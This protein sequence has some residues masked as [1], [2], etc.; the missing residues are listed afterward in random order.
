MSHDEAARLATVQSLVERHTLAIRPSA[1]FDTDR[2][3][4]INNRFYSDQPPALAVMLAG[5]YWI[6]K[7]IGGLTFDN[8]PVLVPYLLT[9]AGSTLPAAGAAGLVYRM[10]RM[11]ELRRT[12]RTALAAVVVFGSGMIAYATTIN[13]YAPA[14]TLVLGA[15][16][17][18][19]HVSRSLRP[20]RQ[21]GWLALGGLCAALAAV[22]EP[23]TLVILLGLPL[24]IWGMRWR[25]S[26]RL[27]GVMLYMIGALAPLVLHAKMVVPVTGDIRPAAWHPELTANPDDDDSPPDWWDTVTHELNHIMRRSLGVHGLL[28]HYPVLI[29][30]IIGIG[31]VMV[32]HWPAT[33]KA[34]AVVTLASATIPLLFGPSTEGEAMYGPWWFMAIA[35]LLAFWIAAFLRRGHT[36]AVWGLAAALLAFSVIVSLFGTIDCAR[37]G[38]LDGYS[39]VEVLRS[40]GPERRLGM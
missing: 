14:A 20:H 24:V 34:L 9:L 37:R 29:F 6:L 11:L 8:S 23:T 25:R 30:G 40:P 21:G 15:A 10:G 13:P 31:A 33:T 7:A 3:V 38:G 1:I 28:T 26:L 36:P 18:L 39:P 4:K 17:S 19:I 2:I 35:P 22:I 32:R 16:A 27:G 12:W 5:V